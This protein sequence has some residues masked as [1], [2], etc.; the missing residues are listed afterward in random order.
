M[1]MAMFN[2]PLNLAVR[3]RIPLVVWGENSAAEY[4]SED[5]RFEGARID[6]EWLRTFGVTH[7]TTAR[8]W[9]GDDLTEQELTPY[10]ART[11]PT[12]TRPA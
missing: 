5:E 1:H 7:G 8:D 3:L 12:S 6:S 9:V 4:G 10:F 2:I 11:P